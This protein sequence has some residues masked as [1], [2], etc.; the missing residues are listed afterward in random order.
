MKII[1]LKTLSD[2]LNNNSILIL[3]KPKERLI[4]LVTVIMYKA[5]VVS[6]DLRCWN[7]LDIGYITSDN[8]AE[9]NINQG[10]VAIANRSSLV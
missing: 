6:K 8:S 5:L 1:D 7:L 2:L 3:E 9:I 4:N 10:Q